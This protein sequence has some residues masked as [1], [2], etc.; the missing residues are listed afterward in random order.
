MLF[1]R[2]RH[3]RPET[4]QKVNL[5]VDLAILVA[6]CFI[7]AS[8]TGEIH[9]RV[10]LAMSATAAVVWAFVSRALRH[11]DVANGRTFLG[12]L[13]LTGVL[14]VA[15]AMPLGLLRLVSPRYATTTELTRF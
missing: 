1:D 2:L 3:P 13:A 11:Y 10:A 12:D 15:V 14:L 8:G 5:V 7:A 9:W 4:T 6:A